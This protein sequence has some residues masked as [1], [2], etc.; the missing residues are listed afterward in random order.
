MSL[1]A[2]PITVAALTLLLL[3]STQL[4]AA[5]SATELV[6]TTAERMLTELEHNKAAIDANPSRIYGLVNRIVVPHFD[7]NKIT[8]A[9]MG[10]HWKRATPA[11]QEQLVEV[12]RER[13][14]RIYANSLRK[15]AGQT[16]KYLPE[17]TQPAS[18]R[19]P[20]RASVPTEITDPGSTPIP[21][22]YSLYKTGKDWKVYNIV[23]SGASLV[24]SARGEIDAIVRRKGGI[25]GLIAELEKQNAKGA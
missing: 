19:R 24:T 11:Q 23:V 17:R 7:F 2:L 1:K 21:I 10:K 25:P 8:R 6:R 22:E 16:I 14:V 12:F 9:A 13:M 18:G 3:T 5:Q 4:L 15:Y 20:E